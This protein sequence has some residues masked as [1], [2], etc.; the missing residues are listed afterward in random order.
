MP[1]EKRR[2]SFVHN[3]SFVARVNHRS[4]ALPRQRLR[5]RTATG[6]M[7]ECVAKAGGNGHSRAPLGRITPHHSHRCPQYTSHGTGRKASLTRAM[8][9]EESR[10]T[11]MVEANAG[12]GFNAQSRRATSHANGTEQTSLLLRQKLGLRSTGPNQGRIPLLDVGG[13]RRRFGSR[14]QNGRCPRREVPTTHRQFIRGVGRFMPKW[15][16]KLGRPSAFAGIS[17]DAAD[18]HSAFGNAVSHGSFGR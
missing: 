12:A 10:S 11:A 2:R 6:P 13:L 5:G 3:G 7:A 16:A 1:Y 14:G 17:E 15:Q 9:A 4:R 8:Q 18:S